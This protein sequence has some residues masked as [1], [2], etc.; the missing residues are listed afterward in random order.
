MRN[1]RTSP[2]SAAERRV[3]ECRYLTPSPVRQI[4]RT[5]FDVRPSHCVRQELGAPPDDGGCARAA[6]A[7]LCRRRCRSF[8]VPC[9]L[10]NLRIPVRRRLA[11]FRECPVVSHT[12]S[13]MRL[14][15]AGPPRRMPCALCLRTLGTVDVE[16]ESHAPMGATA[17]VIIDAADKCGDFRYAMRHGERFKDGHPEAPGE[18]LCHAQD[19]CA[20]AQARPDSDGN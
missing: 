9:A 18:S 15:F 5:T 20:F 10:R 8:R 2:L 6:P 4:A 3:G 11:F 12:S 16:G 7:C 17:G 13:G 14:R 1:P 19:D